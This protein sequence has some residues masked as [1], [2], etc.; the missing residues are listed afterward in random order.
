M[1]RLEE[2]CERYLS[3]R[4]YSLWGA[5]DVSMADRRAEAVRWL[6]DQVRA[7]HEELDKDYP[8]SDLTI[9]DY[10]EFLRPLIQRVKLASYSGDP[11]HLSVGEFDEFKRRLGYKASGVMTLYGVPVVVDEEE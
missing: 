1:T 10:G 3:S 2:A 8:P 11:V 7:V 4:P 6:A 5:Y 9:Q